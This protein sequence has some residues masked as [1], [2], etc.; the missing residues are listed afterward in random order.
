MDKCKEDLF[1]YKSLLELC[2]KRE[3]KLK[4]SS[5]KERLEDCEMYR[6]ALTPPEGP[7]AKE[8]K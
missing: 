2:T 3:K 6:K 4:Q 1:V 7:R 5:L 8:P